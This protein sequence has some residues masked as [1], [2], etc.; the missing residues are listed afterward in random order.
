M[1]KK[2]K[3]TD[4]AFQDNTKFLLEKL[5]VLTNEE[6]HG[7]SSELLC[8]YF[9]IPRQYPFFN[10]SHLAMCAY[11]QWYRVVLDIVKV[12]LKPKRLIILPEIPKRTIDFKSN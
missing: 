3:E 5:V 8:A 10:F 1:W 9:K 2:K 6:E 11:L 4:V 7:P 12:S